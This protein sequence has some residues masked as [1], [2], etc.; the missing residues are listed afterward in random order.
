[1]M[2]HKDHEQFLF[3]KPDTEHLYEET[4]SF[5]EG[6]IERRGVFNP[7]ISKERPIDVLCLNFTK[8]INDTRAMMMLC[9]KGFY[10]Q[11]GI[12]CR[13]AIDACNLMMHI[14]FSGENAE[15]IDPWL[16]RKK[17]THWKV[18][19]NIDN[20]LGGGL[21]LE[22]YRAKREMLD[23]LVHGNYESLKY[24]PAQSPGP[25]PLT[26]EAFNKINS[27][28]SLINLNIIS[29]LLVVNILVPEFSEKSENYLELL[30]ATP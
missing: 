17:M 3:L 10:I 9:S 13:S 12:I 18:L 16:E 2:K 25:T 8:V 4:L 26:T 22:A 5:L 14:A 21:D 15:L 28:R 30:R 7:D 1:M 6:V 23:D 11:A 19:E 29:C 20:T 24:Y 27:W